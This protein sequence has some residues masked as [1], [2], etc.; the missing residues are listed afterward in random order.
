MAG[1]GNILITV[2]AD[3][4]A[5]VRNLGKVNNALG[6]TM[7]TSEKMGA[8]LR[9]AALPAAAALGAIGVAGI[10]AAKAAMEDAQSADHLAQTMKRVAGSS[11]AAVASM[12][13]YIDKTAR[14]TGVADDKLR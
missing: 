1:A 14:A 3:T 10:S 2:G 6:D 9:K 13:D 11:D 8:G 5:A 4:V 12:E 7:S